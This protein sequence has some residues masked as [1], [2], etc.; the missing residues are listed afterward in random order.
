MEKKAG[1]LLMTGDVEG[2]RNCGGCIHRIA[3]I[4]QSP[5]FLKQLVLAGEEVSQQLL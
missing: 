2:Q 5:L 1:M 4:N 3:V